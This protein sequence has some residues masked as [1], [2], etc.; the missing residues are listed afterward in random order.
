MVHG[1]YDIK[2]LASLVWKHEVMVIK[3]QG[4]RT[5]IF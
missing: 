1:M 4:C 5:A 2:T 3:H